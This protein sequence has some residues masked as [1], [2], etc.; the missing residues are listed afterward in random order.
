MLLQLTV[1][2]GFQMF[3]CKFCGVQCFLA[4]GYFFVRICSGNQTRNTEAVNADP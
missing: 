1:A 3:Q 2:P 4:R